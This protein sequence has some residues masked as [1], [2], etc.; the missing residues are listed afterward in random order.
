MRAL[1]AHLCFGFIRT[2]INSCICSFVNRFSRALVHLYFG[3]FVHWLIRK[4][5]PSCI[6]S[7]V[8]WSICAVV[9]SFIYSF[10]QSFIYYVYYYT[11][12]V[13]ICIYIYFNQGRPSPIGNDAFPSVSDC[14]PISTFFPNFTFS[15]QN[16][17]VFIRQN[18]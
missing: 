15:Q 13:C 17:P 8:H 2:L 11:Y 3:S 1:H 6:G 14:P 5:V 4:L 9:H 18:F 16:C 10:V 7:F 12:N